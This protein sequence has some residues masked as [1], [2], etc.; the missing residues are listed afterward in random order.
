MNLYDCISEMFYN[1]SNEWNYYSCNMNFPFDDIGARRFIK[2]YFEQ[3]A[4]RG[5]I[6]PVID[7]INSMRSMHTVSAFFI[8]LLLK[9]GIGEN[10]DIICPNSGD[11]EFSYLWF[12]VCLYHDMGYAV[13]ND[14][15]YK[16]TYRNQSKNFVEK[17]RNI[18]KCYWYRR[19]MYE[20]LGLLFVAPSLYSE[21]SVP[22]RNKDI[23]RRDDGIKFRN[24]VR[25]KRAT[26]TRKTIFNYLEYCKMNPH[27]KH[28]DHGIVGGFWLYDSLMKNYYETYMREKEFDRDIDFEN[29]QANGNRHFSVEQRWIFAYLAD[30]IIS[31]N[32]WPATKEKNEIYKEC[33]LNELVEPNFKKITFWDNPILFI[34]AIADTIEPIKL[35]SGVSGMETIDIWR[36]IDMKF[37]RGGMTIKLLDDR[38]KFS[39]AQTKIKDLENWVDVHTIPGKDN[40]KIEIT[41]NRV[42]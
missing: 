1:D 15:M 3:G 8:G 26:Y 37:E 25:V 12:L 34:L 17:Y 24:G 28:Y 20:D 41:Y 22:K 6:F 36:G 9:K 23:Y 33:D 29:F 11:Y 5:V 16:F 27:I 32:I 39:K 35:Y 38:L 21:F 10:I 18:R 2:A 19:T 14:W 4:K 30:C 42:T 40:R 7:E 31:H 13:E